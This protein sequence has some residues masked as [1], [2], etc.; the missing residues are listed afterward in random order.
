MRTFRVDRIKRIAIVD[1]VLHDPPEGFDAVAHVSSS[2][3]RVPSTWEI[4]VL[5]D[6]PLETARR[7][8]P[9]TLADLTAEEPGTLLR[10]HVGSLDWMASLLAGLDCDFT[11]RRPDELR[12]SVRALADRVQARVS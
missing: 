9:P 2:L 6:L 1:G 4:E 12:D 11:I 10:M 7:R 5:L 8:V 3:A